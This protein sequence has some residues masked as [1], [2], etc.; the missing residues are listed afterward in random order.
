LLLLSE[1]TN[2]VFVFQNMQATFFCSKP[3]LERSH[4]IAEVCG[5]VSKLT[6]TH[7]KGTGPRCRCP[8]MHQSPRKLHW[9]L[10]LR[11]GSA[12]GKLLALRCSR[13]NST[14]G[15]LMPRVS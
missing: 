3:P 8:S 7:H 9:R 13:R 4:C 1:S 10:R 14:R 15:R 6:P 5:P 12:P 11:S 2:V